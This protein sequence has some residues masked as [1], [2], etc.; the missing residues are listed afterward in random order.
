MCRHT[1]QTRT[2]VKA[3]QIR[4]D[5]A[6]QLKR[7][8]DLLKEALPD[9]IAEAPVRLPASVAPVAEA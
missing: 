6:E 5:E 9:K 4:I 7:V 3:V 2:Q 1:A 8:L